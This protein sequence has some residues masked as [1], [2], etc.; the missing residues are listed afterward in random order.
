[1]KI[2]NRLKNMIISI[3][4]FIKVEMVGGNMMIE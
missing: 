4:G 2:Q 3:S 1:M